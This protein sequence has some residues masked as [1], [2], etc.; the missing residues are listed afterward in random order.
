MNYREAITIRLENLNK[1]D[2]HQLILYPFGEQ[3]RLAKSILE[4]YYHIN[5]VAIVDNRL[6]KT[7]QDILSVE[8]LRNMDLAGIKILLTSDR[9]DIHQE[10]LIPLYE[11]LPKVEVIELFPDWENVQERAR[12]RRCETLK[13]VKQL[14]LVENAMCYKPSKTDVTFFLP[15]VYMDF[16]Q[17]TILLTEDYFERNLLDWVFFKYKN[18]VVGNVLK[19]E[20]AGMVLDIGANIGNHSLYFIKELGVKKVISFEPVDETFWILEKNV[21]LNGLQDRIEL[22]QLGLSDQCGKAQIGGYN[23]ANIGQ[24]QIEVDVDG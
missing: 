14:N 12:I 6:S 18:G 23:Y 16:I 22:H 4:E 13:K 20:N 2:L 11:V 15:Y 5:P 21:Q 17:S 24:T 8:E 9:A 10:L 3:G 7:E 1:E 19:D